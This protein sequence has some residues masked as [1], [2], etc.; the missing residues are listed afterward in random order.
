MFL[1]L[2][3]RISSGSRGGSVINTVVSVCTPGYSGVKRTLQLK[4]NE[5]IDSLIAQCSGS[6][7]WKQNF[8]DLWEDSKPWLESSCGKSQLFGHGLEKPH[9]KKKNEGEESCF[10]G[11]E[12]TKRY[13]W[14]H[15]SFWQGRCLDP[16]RAQRPTEPMTKTVWLYSRCVIIWSHKGVD[17]I[18]SAYAEQSSTHAS[19]SW[20]S[21]SDTA[22]QMHFNQAVREGKKDFPG[23]LIPDFHL[24][25]LS[26]L[27]RKEELLRITCE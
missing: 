11:R 13:P 15:P 12:S 16:P 24:N 21:G 8:W 7:R 25:F 4:R 5:F 9:R 19:S 27:A 22:P 17:G 2:S 23:Y 1:W 26:H 20:L 10:Q 14:P 6:T 18:Y 3:I